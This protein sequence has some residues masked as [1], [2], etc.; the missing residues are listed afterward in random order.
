VGG[1]H[2]AEVAA[3]KSGD[4]GLLESFRDRDDAGI[5]STETQFDVLVDEIRNPVIIDGGEGLNVEIAIG[6]GTEEPCFAAG[7]ELSCDEV[8]GFGDDERGGDQRSG[9]LSQEL[10][11]G[12]MVGIGVVGCCKQ[13]TRIDDQHRS[14][15]SEA[16]YEHLVGV[17]G[18]TTRTRRAH[19]HERES[20]LRRGW[21]AGKRSGEL[22][23]DHVDADTTPFGFSGQFA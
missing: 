17:T 19:P 10:G 8:C 13:N 18:P 16:L 2:D 7:A 20:A 11:A 3:V 15:A 4:A 1:P 14:V 6:D 9:L 22:G 23:D 12:A 5:G 21:F